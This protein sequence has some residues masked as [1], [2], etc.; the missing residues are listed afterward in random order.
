MGA[1]IPAVEDRLKT[2]IILAG[3]VDGVGLPEVNQ[4]NYVPRIKIPVLMM[5][6]KYDTI[7]GYENSARPMFE[8]LGTPEEHK[9]IEAY[10]TDHIPPKAEYVR[11][12]LDWLDKY[13][14]PVTVSTN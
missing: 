4:L 12:I 3:G 10:P 2:A 1:I 11:E 9:K 7:I 13:F 8:L 5:S 14:G 6:G